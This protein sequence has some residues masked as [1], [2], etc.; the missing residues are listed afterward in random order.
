MLKKNTDLLQPRVLVFDVHKTHPDM[1]EAERKINLLL[2]SKGVSEL[3]AE[4]RQEKK[5]TD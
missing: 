2:D 3:V 4:H 1:S 5:S